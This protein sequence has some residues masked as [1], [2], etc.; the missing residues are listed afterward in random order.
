MTLFIQT[1]FVSCW[2]SKSM[3]WLVHLFPVAVCWN[4]HHALRKCVKWP[5]AV[6]ILGVKNRIGF[7]CE[8]ARHWWKRE[9]GGVIAQWSRG[10]SL[11]FLW[12]VKI[13]S[14]SCCHFEV[15]KQRPVH[16]YMYGAFCKCYLHVHQ[17]WCCFLN[18]MNTSSS[19]GSLGQVSST[20]VAD[21]W[22]WRSGLGCWK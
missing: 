10:H 18:A 4:T 9:V 21:W 3:F 11:L 13:L 2:L 6:L 12:L 8:Y 14:A 5:S 17:Q 7:C 15:G 19:R 1:A 22:W 20:Q 16:T